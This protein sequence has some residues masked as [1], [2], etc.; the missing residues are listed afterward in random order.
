[1]PDVIQEAQRAI[2]REEYD[3]AIALLQPLADSG[4]PEAQYLLGYLA[5]TSAEVDL[6]ECR[7]W[8]ER[9]AAQQHP[10]AI[11][12]LARW[13]SNGHY[14]SP[15]DEPHRK[16][17]IRAAE[18][19][20]SNAQRDLGCCYALGEEGWPLDL[21][22]ARQWYGRAAESGHADAQFNY[23]VMLLLGEGG[24]IDATG[25]D[26]INRAAAQEDECAIGYLKAHAT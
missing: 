10:E 20:S 13:V 19:G 4:N 2:E 1:M 12:H 3:R 6:A 9:A 23:G 14:A 21:A 11:Y 22:L 8:L 18:L 7:V 17:L 25:T 16:L 26:W 5:F 24:P 15:K